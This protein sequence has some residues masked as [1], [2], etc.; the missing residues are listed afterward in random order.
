[1]DIMELGAMGELVGG[2]AVIG[3]LLYLAL[4]VRQGNEQA[5]QSNAIERGRANREVARDFNSI[6]LTMRDPEFLETYRRAPLNF[7]D[8]SPTDQLA[9]H[10]YL[11]ALVVHASSIFLVERDDLVDQHLAE[12]YVNAWASL[13]SSPGVRSWWDQ[14]KSFY[15]ESFVGHIDELIA[16]GA[17]PPIHE[18]FPWFAAERAAQPS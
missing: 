1:M 4:Q 14:T 5:R 11:T 2:V 6:V 18:V 16:A 3:S 8:T 13:A 9:L 15:H 17:N 12:R 7:E 10:M